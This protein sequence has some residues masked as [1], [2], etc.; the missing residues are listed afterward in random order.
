MVEQKKI[1]QKS[2]LSL[3]R[4]IASDGLGVA[5]AGFQS[6]EQATLALASL[7]DSYA[8]AVGQPPNGKAIKASID[9]LYDDIKMGR[10]FDL[11]RF[12]Q[13]LTAVRG[14]LEQE[15]PAVPSKGESS[16]SSG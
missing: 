4:R 14:L 12:A 10:Q 16:P 5:N 6:A 11:S 15:M 3:M 1:T 13:H 2:A 7:Y 8:D 9:V